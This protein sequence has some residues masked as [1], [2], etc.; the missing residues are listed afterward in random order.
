MATFQLA[1]PAQLLVQV[2]RLTGVPVAVLLS[3]RRAA[4][5]QHVTW[6]GRSGGR[7]ASSGR[8]VVT[9]QATSSVGTSSL[10]APFSFHA[11]KRK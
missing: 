11:H 6:R 1:R 7:R 2:E 10:T 8:Y 4:G 5:T 9:V 3:G